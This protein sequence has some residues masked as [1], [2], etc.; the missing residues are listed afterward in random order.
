MLRDAFAFL[1]VA[2]SFLFGILC[3]KKPEIVFRYM[4]IWYRSSSG[5]NT[6]NSER[7][8]NALRY[9]DDPAQYHKIFPKD[10]FGIRST[11]RTALFVAIVGLFIILLGK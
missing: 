5:G 9:I 11:G 4:A 6:Y 8:I 2:F 10:M 1:L 7:L 3:I